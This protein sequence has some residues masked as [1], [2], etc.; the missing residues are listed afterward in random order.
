MKKILVLLILVFISCSNNST[1]ESIATTAELQKTTKQ[2]WIDS[3]YNQG[4]KWSA[5][6]GEIYDSNT[7]F[8]FKKDGSI[9]IGLSVNQ[10]PDRQYITLTLDE[11]VSATEVYYSFTYKFNGEELTLY[12]GLS[13]GETSTSK[14]A[15]FLTDFQKAEGW[16]DTYGYSKEQKKQW[17]IDTY[18]KKKIKFGK[19]HKYYI[20]LK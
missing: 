2:A 5:P 10:E 8:G 14:P 20:A 18:S 19:Q 1:T 7:L 6:N 15:L 17:L 4:W 12:D 9:M 3:V 13:I 11:A 16:Q